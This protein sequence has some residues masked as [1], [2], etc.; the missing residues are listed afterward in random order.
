MIKW[1]L[2][3][4]WSV[5]KIFTN[6]YKIFRSK[7][8]LRRHQKTWCILSFTTKE[9]PALNGQKHIAMMESKWYVSLWNFYN[10]LLITKN[11]MTW[12]IILLH[13]LIFLLERNRN[14]AAKKKAWL[15]VKNG[16]ARYVKPA[17]TSSRSVKE[18]SMHSLSLSLEKS[19]RYVIKR[20]R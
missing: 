11:D 2:L 19:S 4:I 7:C 10:F 6:H 8:V 17:F 20:K 1:F 13:N 16:A 18:I 9:Q 14:S 12:R 15:Y 3:L 5:K